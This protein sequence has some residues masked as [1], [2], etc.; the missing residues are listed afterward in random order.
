MTG[1]YAMSGDYATLRNK[2]RRRTSSLTDLRRIPM[3]NE[4][5]S[6]TDV[7]SNRK[8]KTPV[9][10]MVNKPRKTNQNEKTD[11]RSDLYSKVNKSKKKGDHSAG[12]GRPSEV[13]TSH[14]TTHT[15]GVSDGAY[16]TI[17]LNSVPKV[18]DGYDTVGN[19]YDS[20]DVVAEKRPKDRLPSLA[21]LKRVSEHVYDVVP[22]ISSDS[23]TLRPVISD[24]EDIPEI[25]T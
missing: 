12:D 18:D 13:S 25:P 1:D 21:T 9:Y 14:V 8:D 4:A 19:D 17:K 24:Y 10:T 20:V 15:P 6:T 5:V 2:V 22:D 23:T 7:S 3:K 16:E 11:D